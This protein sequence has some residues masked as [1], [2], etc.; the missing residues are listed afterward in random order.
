MLLI[1]CCFDFILLID[2]G[3]C[4]VDVFRLA[5]YC[6]IV[7]LFVARCGGWVGSVFGFVILL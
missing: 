4:F 7:C 6:W 2:L 3:L 1:V 5:F